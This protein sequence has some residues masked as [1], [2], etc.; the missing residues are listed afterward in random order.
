MIGA[1]VFSRDR[2]C[3]L[4]LLL[5]S[6]LRNGEGLFDV[7]VIWRGG[8]IPY[9]I[10]AEEHPNTEFIRE[11]GLTYQVRSLV[12]RFKS[13]TFFTDD[14]VLYREVTLEPLLTLAEEQILT[15]SLR[16]GRNTTVCY[17]LDSKQVIPETPDG[18]VMIWRWRG[19]QG[20]FSYPMSVD[21]HIF[22]TADILPL[23]E[24]RHFSTP[25]HLEEI[26]MSQKIGRPLMA[27]YPHSCL[28][29]IP[30]NIVNTTH[31]NRHANS[32]SPADLNAA[33]LEGKRLDL[34]ALDFS[35]IRGA[36]QELDLVL[37]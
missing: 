17:P 25:N 14:S 2:A 3:Q 8:T 28:V 27:S 23:I 16:L 10:C 37:A 5:R 36:H 34:D 21:G 9:G 24:D 33:Y 20:D 1:I 4:D 13:V 26:L 11:N 31:P 22:R 30:A 35:D 7:K 12:R 18:P 6:L 32:H 19:A 29:G 15:F